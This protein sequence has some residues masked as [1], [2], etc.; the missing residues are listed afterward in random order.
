VLECTQC[1]LW[2]LSTTSDTSNTEDQ[3]AKFDSS[4]FRQSRSG[5]SNWRNRVR[6]A[7]RMERLKPFIGSV[8][9]QV[10]EIGPGTG[11]ALEY[12]KERGHDVRGVE[13]SKGLA[14]ALEQA[15]GIPIIHSG[16]DAAAGQFDLVMGFHVLEHTEDPFAFARSMLRLAKPGGYVVNVTPNTGFYRACLPHQI[17][18]KYYVIKEHKVYFNISSAAALSARLKVRL[19]L[20]TTTEEPEHRYYRR[21]QDRLPALPGRGTLARAA[22]SCAGLLQPKQRLK[23]GISGTGDE[24]W[25]VWRA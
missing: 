18:E 20:L 21:I 1:G 24:L 2:I 5:F 4:W 7:Q 10:L 22:A 13:L 19:E 12:L 11:H 6:A 15:C 3:E 16:I 25:I 9:T 14:S 8:P 17:V 23:S